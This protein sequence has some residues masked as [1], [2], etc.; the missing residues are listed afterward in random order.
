[1]SGEPQQQQRL[2]FNQAY[3]TNFGVTAPPTHS[4]PS[5]GLTGM[6][7]MQAIHTE[8]LRNTPSPLQRA[9]LSTYQVVANP[10]LNPQAAA[11]SAAAGVEPVVHPSSSSAAYFQ[12]GNVAHIANPQVATWVPGYE[13]EWMQVAAP[14][15]GAPARAFRFPGTARPSP[16]TQALRQATAIAGS[17]SGTKHYVLGELGGLQ[18]ASP[19]YPL[20]LYGPF[21]TEEQQAVMRAERE[22]QQQQQ[23]EAASASEG[24]KGG[25]KKRKTKAN[26]KRKRKG[27]GAKQTQRRRRV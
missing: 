13:G 5:Y 6:G 1:M 21:Y 10:F 20:S 18:E 4:N 27:K 22:Q 9:D 12:A 11:I 24:H 26:A 14:Y 7:G 3:V 23:Q 2:D 16:E 8:A 15:L 19:E 17:G 25:A